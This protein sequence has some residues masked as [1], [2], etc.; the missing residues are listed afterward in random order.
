MTDYVRQA[1]EKLLSQWNEVPSDLIARVIGEEQFGPGGGN[2]PVPM[3]GTLFKVFGF[4]RDK[5]GSLLTPMGPPENDADALFEWLEDQGG[6]PDDFAEHDI[7]E[8]GDEGPEW[9]VE[10]LR[11]AIQDWWADGGSEEYWLA[12]VGWQHV[13]DTCL[14]AYEHEGEIYVGANSAGHC[15]YESYWIPLYKELGYTWHE[16][17]EHADR[18]A[19]AA[20]KLADLLRE[21]DNLESVIKLTD[22]LDVFREFVEA[23]DG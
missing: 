19:R 11:W 12:S 8:C 3:W 10:R 13:G 16:G 14:Y 9:D 7:S 2:G 17:Y 22:A 4:D 21:V 15:F 23:Y 6:D 20:I 18:Q 1:A 5:V